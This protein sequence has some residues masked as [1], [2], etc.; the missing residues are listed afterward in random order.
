MK[1]YLPISCA[2]LFASAS[3]AQMLVV[4][5][6]ALPGTQ[7][8][9]EPV[10]RA[11]G[12]GFVGDHFRLGAA[13]E[14]W[15]IDTIRVWERSPG[16]L[17]DTFE[18]VAL[19]GGIEAVPPPPGKPPEADCDCHNLI[20]I[21][22]ARYH[23]GSAPGEPAGI[24][25]SA[26]GSGLRQIDFQNLHWSVP[27]GL[28]IQFGVMGVSRRGNQPWL[29]QTATMP[30]QHHL[31]LFDDKGKLEGAYAPDGRPP[32]AGLGVN[33]QV[34]AHRAATI[35]IRPSAA[36]IEVVLRSDDS[37]DATKAEAASLRLG[38]NGAAPVSSRL[39]TQNGRQML[40]ARFQRQGTG[41][42]PSSVSACMN[43]RLSDGVPFEGCDLLRAK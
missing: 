8:A 39:Q 4:D 3:M 15:V 35:E 9:G 2:L 18:S 11:K 32:A 22:S 19:F 36:A 37:F 5:R 12:P 26:S 21:K 25:E 20:S 16:K 30:D 6:P 43:G 24:A 41:L 27:G 10:G 38:P 14:I 23:S 33:V 29:Y 31:N 34:W 7:N 17:G 13:G 28:N 40:V 42:Q 1:L